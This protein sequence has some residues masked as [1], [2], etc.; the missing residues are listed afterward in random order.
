M[1]Q[2]SGGFLL[3]MSYNLI[4]SRFRPV[5]ISYTAAAVAI[6]CRARND[7]NIPRV[8]QA[9]LQDW[10]EWQHDVGFSFNISHQLV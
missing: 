6:T 8:E 9:E 7:N 3:T 4:G 2:D 10:D 1:G 5:T